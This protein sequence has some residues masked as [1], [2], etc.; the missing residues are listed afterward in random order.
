MFRERHNI[1]T[2]WLEV[3]L[4]TIGQTLEPDSVNKVQE[5]VA[6]IRKGFVRL[7]YWT[8]TTGN[9]LRD[10]DR[11][12]ALGKCFKST[13]G[14]RSGENLYFSEHDE[15]ASSGSANVRSSFSV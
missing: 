3:L 1:D 15:S 7:S 11:L 12:M 10:M 14:L 13:L 6:N 2:K 4:T 9:G 8:R 5:V